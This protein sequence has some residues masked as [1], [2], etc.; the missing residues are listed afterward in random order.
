MEFED[1]PVGMELESVEMILD[2]E[3]IDERIELVQWQ[4]RKPLESLGVT[5]PGLT[6]RQHAAMQFITFPEL[7][8]GIWAKSEHE[9]MKPMKAGSRIFIRG[10]IV[11]KYTKRGRN[12]VAAAF[13]TRD[14][15]G[16]LLMKSIETSVYVE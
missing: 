9:F 13:E 10:K 5:A 3:T 7:R 16:E 1:I 6:I 14:E 4:N 12:Y 15:R 8:A 2:K 11:E